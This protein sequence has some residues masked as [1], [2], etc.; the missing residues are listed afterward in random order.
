MREDLND[1]QSNQSNSDSDSDEDDD[2]SGGDN[3]VTR[4]APAAHLG[5]SE[6][7][8]AV[9]GSNDWVVSGA[10]TR[11]SNAEPVV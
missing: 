11:A 5:F 8:P 10:H 3:S 4:N 1:Q 7:D 6:G 9:N 2:D